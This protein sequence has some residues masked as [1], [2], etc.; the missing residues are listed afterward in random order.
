[1]IPNHSNVALPST[2]AL[3]FGEFDTPT[4]GAVPEM[5]DNG[6][7]D[8]NGMR[9]QCRLPEDPGDNPTKSIKER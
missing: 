5:S 7:H 6:N 2:T 9:K 4:Y 1:M 3:Y 8:G